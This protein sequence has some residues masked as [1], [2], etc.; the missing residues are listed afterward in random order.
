MLIKA[1]PQSVVEAHLF[2][3]VLSFHGGR[4]SDELS[5]NHP[6]NTAVYAK[7]VGAHKG[8]DTPPDRPSIPQGERDTPILMRANQSFAVLKNKFRG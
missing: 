8:W 3:S 2:A 1:D 5:Q 6:R 7:F 4:K